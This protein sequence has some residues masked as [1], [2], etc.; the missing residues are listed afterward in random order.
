[1]RDSSSGPHILQRTSTSSTTPTHA[2]DRVRAFAEARCAGYEV[3]GSLGHGG[4]GKV[5]QV[6]HLKTGSVEA[7]KVLG[8]PPWISVTALERVR[9][10]IALQASIEHPN[11]VRFNTARITN[12]FALLFMELLDGPSLARRLRFGSLPLRQSLNYTAQIACALGHLHENG[13][14]HRDVKPSNIVVTSSGV[15]KLLDFG[16]ARPV[17]SN[18]LLPDKLSARCNICRGADRPRRHDRCPVGHLLSWCHLV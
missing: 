9:R 14:L 17:D 1:M 6:R 11:I 8:L 18:L 5:F 12:S 15:A 16:V 2:N 7:M 10:E 4:G 13:I 3:L